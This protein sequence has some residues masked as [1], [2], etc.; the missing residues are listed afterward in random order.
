MPKH[1]L[2]ALVAPPR[3][4]IQNSTLVSNLCK[5]SF[6]QS[7]PQFEVLGNWPKKCRNV[8]KGSIMLASIGPKILSASLRIENS[9]KRIR[10]TWLL[11]V[12]LPTPHPALLIR[13]KSRTELQI[14][15]QMQFQYIAGPF[16]QTG[17]RSYCL[18]HK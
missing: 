11:P 13:Q 9:A 7:Q 12:W 8:G 16:V 18:H 15:F 6:C 2:I 3:F 14:D 10:F 17:C 1:N 4:G 5:N